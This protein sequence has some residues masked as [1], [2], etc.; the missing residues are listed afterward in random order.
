MN[1]SDTGSVESFGVEFFSEFVHAI[2]VVVKGGDVEET[3]CGEG[4]G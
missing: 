3:L 4:F 2:E 1:K